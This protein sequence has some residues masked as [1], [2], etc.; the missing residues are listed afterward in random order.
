MN[1]YKEAIEVLKNRTSKKLENNTYLI[2]DGENIA[3]KLHQTNVVTYKPNGD[4]VLNSGGWKTVT[5]K[6]RINKYSNARIFQKNNQWFLGDFIFN[7][8][9]IISKGKVK[10]AL[11]NTP[12]KEKAFTKEKKVIKD[13][14]KAFVTALFDGKVEKPSS[15][16]C[17]V[18]LGMFQNDN[19]H[20]KDHIEEGYFVPS[21][22]KQALTDIPT[23]M[24]TKSVIQTFWNKENIDNFGKEFAEKEAIKNLYRF[25][26][27]KLGHSNS[28]INF[29]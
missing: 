14:C 18:C 24:L 26:M 15:G 2:K 4:I 25:I 16:D 23:S 12:V 27:Q 10:N 8:G 6:D 22:L 5:T 1:S 13:Y 7:D 19:E 9:V 28:V 11:K 20:I 29:K 21:L 17:W 3:I